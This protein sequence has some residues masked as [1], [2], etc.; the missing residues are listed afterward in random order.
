[1]ILGQESVTKRTYAAGARG[2]DG[3]YTAGA[4]TDSTILASIQPM[5]GEELAT[6][7]E[8][9]RHPDQ[10]KC[11][12]R[13]AL[14]AGDIDAGLIADHILVDG[15]EYEVRQVERQRAVLPHYKARL[16]RMKESG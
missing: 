10:R 9:E 1:M 6:L 11:Y 16:V 14:Q 3:R 2:T 8:G 12:T 15:I 13:T 5:N 7:P 4:A